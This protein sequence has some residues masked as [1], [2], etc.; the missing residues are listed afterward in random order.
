VHLHDIIRVHFGFVQLNGFGD[1]GFG[2]D[3]GIITLAFISLALIFAALPTAG[4][5]LCG[6]GAAGL[7]ATSN[8][9]T[10]SIIRLK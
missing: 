7:Q 3:Q 6:V 1:I 9:K 4:A 2:S 5:A 10:N 8:H